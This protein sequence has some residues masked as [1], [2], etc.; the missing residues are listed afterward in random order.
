LIITRL[1]AA[2][3]PIGEREL[4]RIVPGRDDADNADR[5]RDQAVF[6]RPELQRGRNTLRRHPL[7]QVL[8]G[9]LDLG[10]QEQRFGNR[11]LDGGAVAEIG[12]D[13][14]REAGLV[15]GDRRAQPLQP[16]EA[17]LVGRRPVGAR[18][19]EHAMEGVLQGQEARALQV[20]FQGLVHLR[21]PRREL[22]SD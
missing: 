14:L 18:A 4:Q 6:G 10:E 1:P 9:V 13:R 22:R 21:S 12:R 15:L 2:S 3:A 11:G 16:V 8:C 19:I 7:L 17:R 20:A 5:L